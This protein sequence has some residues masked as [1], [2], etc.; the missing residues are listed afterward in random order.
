[1]VDAVARKARP[2]NRVKSR[3]LV[4]SAGT[5]KLLL[6]LG[7]IP[8]CAYILSAQTAPA[9]EPIGKLVDLG[10]HKLHVNCTGNGSP[11]VVVENG[12]GDFSFDWI[13]VQSR[14]AEFTRICTYDRAGYAWSDPG[15][16]PQTFAQINSDLHQALA[17]LGEHGPF[18]L[19]GH[20]FGGPVVRNFAAAYPH[21][22]AGMVLVDSAH[23]GLRVGIG[24]GKTIRLGDGAQG[25]A[26]PAPHEEIAASDK[27]AIRA[28]DLPAEL[29]TLDPMFKVLPAEE[30]RE[31]L[32]A[33]QQPAVY[34]AQNSE[35]GWSDEYFAKWLAA[36][37]AGALGSIPLIVLSRADGGYKDGDSDI[38]AAQLEKE[39][40]EGQAKLALLSSNG[41]QVILNCGHNMNLEKPDDVAAAIRDVVTAVRNHG[42]AE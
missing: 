22:V 23:E 16:K 39:R 42:K 27:P 17:R 3:S 28:E 40:K 12:L 30:Q 19:V 37:Q 13:L 29:K 11:T 33:Q 8:L 24:G 18:V 5:F 9:P 15:P 41:R 14:V 26:I 6:Y 36:P 38:P 32:W 31:Q 21:D 2:M 34:D 25:R 35:T 10:T 1:M 20:S 4:A 7:A